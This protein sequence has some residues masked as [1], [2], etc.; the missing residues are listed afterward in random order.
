MPFNGHNSTHSA[1]R[2]GKSKYRPRRR[3]SG[4]PPPFQLTPRDIDILRAVARYRFLTSRHICRLI[5]G[6]GKNITLRLK[7]LFEHR[8][9]DRPECQYDHYRPGGGSSPIVYAL[10]DRGAAVL[11]QRDGLAQGPRVSWTQKNTEVGRPFLEHT[12]E[13]ADFAVGLRES[14]K[15]RDDIQLVDGDD[16]L[17]TLPPETRALQKPYR[18][19]VPVIYRSMRH[20]VGVE[21][22]YAFSLVRPRE[23]RR[24]FFLVEIDR[25]TMPVERHDLKQ[26]SILRKLLAYQTLWKAKRHETHFGWR[27]FRV[28][29]VTTS[30]ERIANIQ[31]VMAGHATLKESVL[32][33]FGDAT[34]FSSE[35]TQ[36]VSG[37]MAAVN[38]SAIHL[39]PLIPHQQ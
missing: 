39:Q 27:N 36:G 1:T 33:L 30:P 16:L 24:A 22:D 5:E 26:T 8:Y 38:G 20:E 35:G 21:P 28:L 12:L 14:L 31:A 10:G 25:G 9:L 17:A 18:L 13:I 37:P 2:T 6:S 7:A 32:F 29:I 23:R 15:G 11:V 19:S 4:A 34:S 3:R